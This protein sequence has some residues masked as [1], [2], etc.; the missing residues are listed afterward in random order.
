MSPPPL[1][2]E[3]LEDVARLFAILSEPSRL[4]ILQT[5]QNGP[6]TVSQI[7]LATGL[8]QANVS[9][10]LNLLHQGRLVSRTR[11]GN[12]IRYAIADPIVSHLCGAVCEKIERDAGSAA[13]RFA[14]TRP[15]A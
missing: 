3:Q 8:R 7:V 11:D 4:A 15:S 14:A 13:R 6:L 5:L 2:H 9:R 1:S 12:H 10:H